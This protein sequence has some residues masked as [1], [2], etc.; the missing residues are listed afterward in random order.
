MS[1]PPSARC[2]HHIPCHEFSCRLQ[3][4]D[5][6]NFLPV[7]SGATRK[8]L[9]QAWLCGGVCPPLSFLSLHPSLV[10]R[11]KRD[12]VGMCSPCW[13]LLIN[14]RN[15]TRGC[16]APK[17]SVIS[18]M[19]FAK[20]LSSPASK[21]GSSGPASVRELCVTAEP[22]GCSV[23]PWLILC[24]GQAVLGCV[25]WPSPCSLPQDA[26]SMDISLLLSAAYIIFMHPSAQEYPN[27][28]YAPKRALLRCFAACVSFPSCSPLHWA[29]QRCCPC[30]PAGMGAADGG[31][32]E[33]P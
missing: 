25:Q 16:E 21:Q 11:G 12:V 4:P 24:L 13:V 17:Q 3:G 9:Q 8:S 26:N 31:D 28:L 1:A 27:T 5:K 14:M 23:L 19:G 30:S 20:C 6:G 33:P 2:P 32:K 29:V 18:Y 15:G 22:Q 7:A 10:A